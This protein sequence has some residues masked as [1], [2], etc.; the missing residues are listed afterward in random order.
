MVP[1]ARDC[2]E[3]FAEVATAFG[4]LS[5][6]QIEDCRAIAAR[7][8]DVGIGPR[9]LA[10]IALE[11]DYLTFAQV[12]L[13]QRKMIA[14]GA[15]PRVAGFE[16]LGRLGT[17]GMATVYKA[18]QVSLNRIVA[19]KILP[20]ELAR[21]E[22]YLARF[23]R[24]AL[25]AARLSHPNIVHVYDVGHADGQ[26]YIVME[27]VNG[28]SLAKVL[29]D[30]PLDEPRA[31]EIARDVAA[32]L[33]HAHAQGIVHR[34]IK[35]S[36]ILIGADGDVKL[37]DLGI[38][39][40]MEVQS[41]SLTQTG[42]IL[43]TPEYMAPEQ[44]ESPRNADARSDIYSLGATL[45]HMLTGEPPFL[46]E[47]PYA[48]MDKHLRAD[49]PDPRQLNPRLSEAVSAL[50]RKMMAK[51]PEERFQSADEVVA[52]ICGLT[53]KAV[54]GTTAGQPGC[55]AAG[56]STPAPM[57]CETVVPTPL[58]LSPPRGTK[59]V[60]LVGV[61]GVLTFAG[62]VA[63]AWNGSRE[64][65]Q[66]LPAAVGPTRA[67]LT[68]RNIL[69]TQKSGAALTQMVF[70]ESLLDKTVTLEAPYSDGLS[71]SGSDRISVQHAVMQV[72]KQVGVEYNWSKSFSN[73]KPECQRY[74]RPDI[75]GLPC[76]AALDAILA[77]VNLTWEVEE[78]Q[79]VLKRRH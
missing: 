29:G 58:P 36:N 69:H 42:V 27:F 9:S 11:K 77:P 74:V 31:L 37:A 23:R 59:K 56:L 39:R 64:H 65:E 41:D 6:A 45:F 32:A 68:P 5:S 53:E 51:V 50:L 73:T 47:T 16:L 60:V 54:V 25:L 76:R 17:G 15:Y 21:D 43:G 28:Q 38:A 26:Q 70:E 78:G 24:E 63:V 66:K 19:L 34:D 4:F 67:D 14:R 20:P 62:F 57:R 18:R 44:F 61:F 75:R 3:V 2:E 8:R 46:G 7:M 10:Q 40:V 13:I 33:G 71:D 49:V 79:V 48:I 22:K 30:G 52:V 1:E 12:H 35:P 55:S 72:L